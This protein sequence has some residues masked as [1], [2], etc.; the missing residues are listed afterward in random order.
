MKGQCC[1]DNSVWVNAKGLGAGMGLGVR[2]PRRQAGFRGHY[3]SFWDKGT[4][5]PSF[6][7]PPDGCWCREPLW[8][9]GIR[10]WHHPNVHCHKATLTLRQPPRSALICCHNGGRRFAMAQAGR[11]TPT[12]HLSST[13]ARVAIVYMLVAPLMAPGDP[14]WHPFQK[15]NA[16][17]RDVSFGY[18]KCNR[19]F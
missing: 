7:L 10:P 8:C 4:T 9:D 19:K 12:T 11:P 18:N 14:S 5:S 15:F 3:C 16:S 13:P 1:H 6:D 17:E 2:G